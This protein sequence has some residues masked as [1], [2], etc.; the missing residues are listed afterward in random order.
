MS[1]RKKLI[2]WYSG[3]L[4]IIII[5]FGVAVF[6]VLR[7]ALIS[8][9]DRELETTSEQVRANSRGF[10]IGEFGGPVQVG[11]RLPELDVF[12][13]SGT[14]VQVWDLSEDEPQLADA[15]VN[16]DTYNDPLDMEALQAVNIRREETKIYSNIIRNDVEWRVLTQSLN[17]WGRQ[18]GI[19]VATSFQTIRDAAGILVVIMLTSGGVGIIGSIAVGMWLSSRALKPIHQITEAAGRIATTDDLKTRLTWTGPL[20]ELG[21]LVSVFNHMMSRLE[22]LFSVQQRFVGDVSHELRTPLTAIRGNIDLVKR[23]GMDATSLEAIDSEAERMSRLVNDLLLL[24][25]ADY[26]ELKIELEPLDVDDIV[27]EA[28]REARVL[29]KD[30]DLTVRIVDFEPV[31]VNGNADRVKQLLLNLISNAIKFTPDGGMVTLN[32][33]R[34]GQEAVLQVADTGVGIGEEDMRRIFDRFYQADSSRRKDDGDGFGLG[35]AIAKWIVDAHSGTI[36]VASKLGE[37]TTFTVTIPVLGA[38]ELRAARAVT[39]RSIPVI[40]RE[41]HIVEK[42]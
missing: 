15:T 20:D 17:I 25:R 12:A 9:V 39:R 29:A 32:L 34:E 22:H 42:A 2:L 13:L 16:I 24:A 27:T 33:R 14:V 26:G 28:Y 1:I 23:Y 35:L 10:L 41:H 18:I 5:I 36:S 37:G 38:D 30:R 7:W 3:L 21:Q 8:A 4:A 19:Q 11:V 40:D 31:R 6:S